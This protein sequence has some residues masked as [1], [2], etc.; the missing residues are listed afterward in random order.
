MLNYFTDKKKSKDL[1]LAEESVVKGLEFLKQKQYGRASKEFEQSAKYDKETALS[2]L[3][4]Q[5]EAFDSQKLFK[6][7]STIG[8]TLYQHQPKTSEFLN[9]LGNLS[10]KSGNS[11][12]ANELYKRAF[13]TNKKD[14]T[15]FLN[16]AA[17]IAKIPIYDQNVKKLIAKHINLKN[18]I[19][20]KS[21][22]PRNQEL[23]GHLAEALNKKH[24]FKKVEKMQEM[25]LEKELKNTTAAIADSDQMMKDIRKKL[26]GTDKIDES[27][28]DVIILLKES[29]DHDWNRL[30]IEE[31]DEFLWSVLNLGLYVLNE[32]ESLIDKENDNGSDPSIKNLKMALDVFVKLKAEQHSFRYLDMVISITHFLLNDEED[33]DEI[34]TF[35]DILSRDPDDRYFNINLGIYYHRTG[36]KLMSYV[37]LIKGASIL[38]KLE[39][40]CYLSDIIELA[41]EKYSQGKLSE[42]LKLYRVASLETNNIEILIGIGKTL[43]TLNKFYEAIQP[44]KDALRLNPKSED[45]QNE[46]LKLQDHFCFLGDEFYQAG[47]FV[48][49]SENYQHA[50]EIDHTPHIMLKAMQAYKMQG[51]IVKEHEIRDEFN[52]I[53]MG[54]KE[55]EVENN[56]ILLIQQGKKQLKLKN[57]NQAITL[58]ENAFKIK[59]DRDTFMYLVYLYKKLNQ[60]QALNRVVQRWHQEHPK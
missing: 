27:C 23:L 38:E 53:K 57:L 4:P 46:L 47:T 32:R 58:F 50:L 39:G 56:R 11:K 21:D 17:S 44:L 7:A 54:Q 49:A 8:D 29:L 37:Y 52:T 35:K 40:A 59:T 1:Q 13:K 34:N 2:L 5:F 45:V 12:K 30:S 20:P 55:Q 41:D 28:S 26:V 43:V 14:D 3:K 24:Y 18:F 10:R 48:V 16:L 25:I 15:A 60:K 51:N 22:Y 36:N 9:H 42:A 31:K 19:I 6:A 33:N